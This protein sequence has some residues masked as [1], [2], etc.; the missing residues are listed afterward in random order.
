MDLL[1][2]LEKTNSRVEYIFNHIFHHI[3]GLNIQYTT[4]VNAFITSSIPKIQYSK[5]PVSNAL[6]FKSANLLF[7]RDIRQQDVKTSIYKNTK[8]FFLSSDESSC[9][10]FDPFAASFYM[11]T[12]YEEYLFHFKDDIGRFP[13]NKTLAYTNG[14]LNIPVVDYWILDIKKILQKRFS[15]LRFKKQTFNFINTIG[16]STTAVR[17]DITPSSNSSTFF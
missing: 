11:L 5:K 8:I 13:A 2:Y 12:R 1:I 10:P 9:V 17:S 16:I 14:F 15:N 6:F 7:E 3:L 4:D